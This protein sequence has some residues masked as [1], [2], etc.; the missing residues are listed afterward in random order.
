MGALS[1]DQ[2]GRYNHVTLVHIFTSHKNSQ[3]PKSGDLVPPITNYLL[4]VDQ[5]WLTSSWTI[6]NVSVSSSCREW[7]MMVPGNNKRFTVLVKS[8]NSFGTSTHSASANIGQ[9]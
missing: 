7:E 4:T 2:H 8:N 6:A 1:L 9:L 5:H 3:R